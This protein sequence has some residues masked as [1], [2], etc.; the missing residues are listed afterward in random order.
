MPSLNYSMQNISNI[1]LYSNYVDHN[2]ITTHPS[3][4]KTKLIIQKFSLFLYQRQKY[5]GLQCI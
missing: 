5:R 3:I 2:F 4:L 1:N